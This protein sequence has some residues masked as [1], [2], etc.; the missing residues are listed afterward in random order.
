MELFKSKIFFR[1]LN[2]FFFFLVELWSDF[3]DGHFATDEQKWSSRISKMWWLSR[4]KLKFYCLRKKKKS[5]KKRKKI[6]DLTS[7]MCWGLQ[8]IYVLL[9]SACTQNVGGWTLLEQS[10]WQLRQLLKFCW[11]R[12]QVKIISSKGGGAAP[13]WE[14]QLCLYIITASQ[15]LTQCL[16]RD[17]SSLTPCTGFWDCIT[18]DP[19]PNDKYSTN[20]WTTRTKQNAPENCIVNTKQKQKEHNS[21]VIFN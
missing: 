3:F 21:F 7:S 17:V 13:F 16:N 14:Y 1:F 5:K 4:R 18:Q 12:E 15:F 11:V 19:D 2:F 6:F 8:Q 10:N 9:K 20:I